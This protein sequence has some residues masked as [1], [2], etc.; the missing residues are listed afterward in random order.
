MF[1]LTESVILSTKIFSIL[2]YW[3]WNVVYGAYLD[4]QWLCFI[5]VLHSGNLQGLLAPKLNGP[6]C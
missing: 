3:G 4:S 1:R 2:A 5:T 6:T